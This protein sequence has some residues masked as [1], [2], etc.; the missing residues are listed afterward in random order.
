ML[1]GPGAGPGHLPAFLSSGFMLKSEVVRAPTSPRHVEAQSATRLPPPPRLLCPS[2]VSEP[3]YCPV[4]LGMTTGRLQSG[5]NT[6]QGF[7]EDKRNKVAPGKAPTR[8]SHR[9]L[10]CSY[11][12]CWY[13]CNFNSLLTSEETEKWCIS[14]QSEFYLFPLPFVGKHSLVLLLHKHVFGGNACLRFVCQSMR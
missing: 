8:D 4:R 6:L 7:K 3:G 12:L 14:I 13:F 1:G 2:S 10:P 9:L 5:V 11:I